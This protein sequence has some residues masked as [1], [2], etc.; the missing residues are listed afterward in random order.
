M[1]FPIQK[2]EIIISAVG[3]DQYPNLLLPE[4]AIA[5]RSNV[6]KSSLINKLLNRKKLA[7]TSSKPGR[8]RTIN[9]FNI[10]DELI[11]V[12]VPGYG[13]AKVSKQ[14]LEKWSEML[15][16]YFETRKELEKV[17]LIVDFRH[18]PTQ[19]DVQMYEYLKYLNLPV[20]ILATKADKVKPG[21]RD[22][23]MQQVLNTLNVYEEDDVVAFSAITGEGVE[24]VW[25]I[26]LE[27]LGIEAK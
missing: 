22:R 27:D 24:T 8:T 15:E 9:F 19:Q 2:A 23:H 7:R 26:I 10:A 17:I 3:E 25:E 12:D 4:V 14:E 1:K 6:G 21:V 11:F 20:L 18:K 5:G 13:Y 16:H